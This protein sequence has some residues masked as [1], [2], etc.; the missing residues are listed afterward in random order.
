MYEKFIIDETKNML[1]V[2]RDSPS[3]I[4]LGFR[5][6]GR[7]F[8]EQHGR[9]FHGREVFDVFGRLSIFLHCR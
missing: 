5:V 7:A 6:E 3:M 8:I 4:N 9:S 2:V 1:N